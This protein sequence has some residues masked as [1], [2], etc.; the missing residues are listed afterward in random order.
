MGSC[1][2]ELDPEL[3]ELIN[4]H[5]SLNSFSRLWAAVIVQAAMDEDYNYFGSEEYK[6]HAQLAGV[7]PDYI[8]SIIFH[9]FSPST[10]QS[11][12]DTNKAE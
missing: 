4:E 8:I 12:P 3:S 10:Q 2:L 11:P 7:D 6:L 9:D 1:T 5:S